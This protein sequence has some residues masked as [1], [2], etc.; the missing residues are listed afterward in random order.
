VAQLHVH[1]VARSSTDA[2]WPQPVWGT[3]MQAPL[4]ELMEQRCT[5]LLAA[6]QNAL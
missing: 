1:I 4:P 6:L 3:Q 5:Q 2:C